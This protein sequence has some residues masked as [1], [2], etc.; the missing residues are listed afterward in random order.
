MPRTVHGFETGDMPMTALIDEIRFQPA[1]KGGT[2][3]P[4]FCHRG[5]PWL[6]GETPPS[7]RPWRLVGL[8]AAVTGQVRPRDFPT[9]SQ[10]AVVSPDRAS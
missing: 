7:D 5:S 9:A 4:A 1:A 10:L 2:P 6:D 3:S 8:A